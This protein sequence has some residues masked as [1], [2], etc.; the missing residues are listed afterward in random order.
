MPDGTLRLTEPD[1]LT[2]STSAPPVVDVSAAPA[3][4]PA[5]EASRHGGLWFKG[6]APLVLIVLLVLT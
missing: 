3:S 6:L 4:P 2:A 5:D 1:E